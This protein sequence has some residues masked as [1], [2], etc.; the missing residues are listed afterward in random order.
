M[1]IKWTTLLL[2]DGQQLKNKTVDFLLLN[3][4]LEFAER[5]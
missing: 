4:F 2:P 1:R 5:F 3:F